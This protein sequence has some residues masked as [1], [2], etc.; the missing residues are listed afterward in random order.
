MY[1]SLWVLSHYCCC[2]FVFVFKAE[3]LC[4]NCQTQ[5]AIAG[6]LGDM[7]KISIPG[8]VSTK[9][10]PTLTPKTQLSE[11]PA[12]SQEPTL[13]TK[14]SPGKQ[15]E[16]KTTPTTVENSAVTD[17]A[18]PAPLSV[19][20]TTDKLQAEMTALVT[21]I[22]AAESQ[23]AVIT[24]AEVNLKETGKDNV[25]DETQVDRGSMSMLPAVTMV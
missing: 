7:G 4:L 19:V 15:A 23:K 11:T 10:K 6:Q 24:A 20:P 17:P 21:P 3:W 2:F 13:K 5:R 18:V 8:P 25:P 9:D 22:P 1:I 14:P 12:P 16:E